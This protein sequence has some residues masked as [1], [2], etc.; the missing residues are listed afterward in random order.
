MESMYGW[1]KLCFKRNLWMR[2]D[3]P[4]EAAGVKLCAGRNL[5]R[6]ETITIN[7]SVWT[8]ISLPVLVTDL[9]LN[10]SLYDK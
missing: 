7:S 5:I 3:G 10:I 1:K 6:I 8:I 4:L 2:R 9:F